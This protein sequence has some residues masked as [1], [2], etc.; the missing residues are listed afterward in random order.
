VVL[1]QNHIGEADRLVEFGRLRAIDDR[2][3]GDF[4][5]ICCRLHIL[6]NVVAI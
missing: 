3:Y 2:P 6:K 4:V 1:E 5:I